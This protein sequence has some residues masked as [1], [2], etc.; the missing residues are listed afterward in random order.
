MVIEYLKKSYFQNEFKREHHVS[1]IKA[2]HALNI[3]W[4][5]SAVTFGM[6]NVM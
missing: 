4:M 3:K 5:S 1:R 2:R 6:R